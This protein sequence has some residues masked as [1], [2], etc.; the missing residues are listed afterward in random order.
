MLEQLNFLDF[1]GSDFEA[2]KAPQK[3]PKWSPKQT[4][5]ERK[6][7]KKKEGFEDPLGSVL[8]LS[9]VVLGSILESNIKTFIGLTS[10]P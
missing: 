1:F 5:I 6:N 7:Q 3:G 10:V 9:W 8:G 4:K 2:Q